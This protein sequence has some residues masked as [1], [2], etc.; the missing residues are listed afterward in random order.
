M[1]IT[2][3]K[4]DNIWMEVIPGD[5]GIG[6]ELSEYFTFEVD[7]AKF[8]PAYKNGVWDGK[9]RLYDMRTFKLYAGLLEYVKTF[10]KEYQY[11]IDIDP[12]LDTEDEFFPIEDVKEWFSK[13]KF[14]AHGEQI[15]PKPYQKVGFY[16]ALNH[17]RMV[18]V[19][20]TSS[21]KSLVIYMIAKRMLEMKKRVLIVVPTTTLVEQMVGDFDDYSQNNM[22]K[23]CHKIF[24]GKEKI[25]NAPVV[26]T[27]W[28][29]VFKLPKKWF[30]Q[31][32]C[33]MPDECHGAQANSMKKIL[34]NCDAEYR[35]GFTGTM[36]DTK[37]H[38]LVIEGLL[39]N[40]HQLIDI[41]Q[42][43]KDKVISQCNIN[44][45]TLKYPDNVKEKRTYPEE[46][47][48]L[49]DYRERTEWITKLVSKTKGNSFVLFDRVRHGEDLFEK[50]SKACPDKN[51]H[52]VYGKTKTEVRNE[53][54]SVMEGEDN[55]V[56]VAGYRVF[57]TGI[58]VRNLHHV[59]FASPTKSKFRVLQSVGR[60]LRLHESKDIATV[61]DISDDL[62]MGKSKN[63]TL[64]HF[65][66]RM[67]LYVDQ[68]FKYK[69]RSVNLGS[70]LADK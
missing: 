32:D 41:D 8:M 40:S 54:R 19:S 68:K 47:D 48:F 36:H 64:K 67:K 27:T 29:S 65:L 55:F 60:V 34:E 11:S 69:I 37:C 24:S 58:S 3:R 1:D 56:I 30:E 38:R 62:S 4:I 57:S 28:Q 39:G 33:V 12:E 17:K 53:L 6:F 22:G 50:I 61:W 9:I 52:L 49:I 14:F 63:H 5:Q 2:I 13:Q 66:E 10:A 21:G 59:V 70:I 43:M 20:P 7:G 15:F 42:L 45:I 44:C 31:F 46:I 51:V 23:Y 16:K 26:V 18:C 25:T 35:I